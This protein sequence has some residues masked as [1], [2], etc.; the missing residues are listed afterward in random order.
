[1]ATPVVLITGAL[2]GIGEATALAFGRIGANIVVT[3]RHPQKGH[4]LVQTLESM[5]A[6]ALFCETDVR[7]EEQIIHMVE[8]TIKHFGRLDVAVN[9]AGIEGDLALLVDQNAENVKNVFDTNIFGVM[10]AMKHELRVMV[11][12]KSGAIINISSVVGQV[13][14]VAAPAYCASKHAVEGLTKSAALESIASGVRV[15][16]IAPGPVDTDMLSRFAGHDAKARERLIA[17]TPARRVAAPDE[18]AQTIIFLASHKAPALTGQI[19]AIDG[20]YL[21]R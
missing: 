21:A 19:I 5:G 17:M 2:S 11:P 3:G 4:A 8:E 18:I 6:K 7:H 12:Q 10:M 15:N 1:M 16:A 9:N 14:T 20:G 13:G